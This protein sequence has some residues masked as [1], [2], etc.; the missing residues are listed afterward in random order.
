V[1]SEPERI[2]QPLLDVL[3][4]LWEADGTVHGHMIKRLTKRSGPT[5]Y[6]N[7]DRLAEAGWII[8]TW[9]DNPGTGLPPRRAYRFTPEGRAAAGQVLAK[10]GR[11]APAI[12]LP[13]SAE[14]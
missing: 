1:S 7:L 3:Q 4:V 13:A 5:V 2:T 10:A 14:G 8:G 12:L 9:Q 11:L 6:N